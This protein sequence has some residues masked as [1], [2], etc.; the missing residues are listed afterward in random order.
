[1]HVMQAGLVKRFTFI[2]MLTAPDDTGQG[3]RTDRSQARAGTRNTELVAFLDGCLDNNKRD[4][5]E[6]AGFFAGEGIEAAIYR[7]EFTHRQRREYFEQIDNGL[8]SAALIFIDPDVGL[9][10]QQS[11]EK[12]LLYSEIKGLYQRMDLSSILMLY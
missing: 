3:G 2:P 4:I 11:G 1:M 12:H 10:V 7:R 8:L 5:K 9:E 6:L